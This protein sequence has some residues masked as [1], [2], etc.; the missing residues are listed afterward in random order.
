M[1]RPLDLQ[2]LYMNL[3]KVG[4]EQAQSKEAVA[5]AQAAQVQRLQR[6]HDQGQHAVGKVNAD[7]GPEEDNAVKVKADGR[8][9]G[10]QGRAK[11]KSEGGEEDSEDEKDETT[12][13]D[14]E[15]GKH[16]DLSG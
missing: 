5:Q 4:K 16:V 6:E 1:I 15:L 2:T 11:P 14:P 13:K 7:V 9:S 10:P 3:E 8:G 12:W